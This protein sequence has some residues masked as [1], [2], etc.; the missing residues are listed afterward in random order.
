MTLPLKWRLPLNTDMPQKQDIDSYLRDLVKEIE[1]MYQVLADNIHDDSSGNTGDLIIDS[2]SPTVTPQANLS[3]NH[4][5]G[6]YA[7]R[8]RQVTIYSLINYTYNSGAYSAY[9]D[10]AN[11]PFTTSSDPT[12]SGF[13]FNGIV[14]YY[15]NAYVLVAPQ[16][17]VQAIA[18]SAGHPIQYGPMTTTDFTGFLTYFTD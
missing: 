6:W 17:S 8:G 13:G 4:S 10:I 2:W 11:L 12:T 18:Y 5:E 15:A 16:N 9:M 1:K 7:K 14:N 3:V